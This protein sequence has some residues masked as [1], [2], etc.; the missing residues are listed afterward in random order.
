MDDLNF[1]YK[2]NRF[3]VFGCVATALTLVLPVYGLFWLDPT[4]P[5]FQTTF[6]TNAFGTWVGTWVG[7]GATVALALFSIHFSAV[8]IKD[9]YT[10][11]HLGIVGAKEDPPLA[12]KE[13]NDEFISYIRKSRKEIIL[14]GS[15]LS[16]FFRDSVFADEFASAVKF[17]GTKITIVFLDPN[18]TNFK[19]RLRE[20]V[21]RRDNLAK[22]LKGSLEYIHNY[23]DYFK[24]YIETGEIRIFMHNDDPISMNIF[25]KD[26]H[27]YVYLPRT[28]NDE[29]P[30]LRMENGGKFTNAVVGSLS[31][32]IDECEKRADSKIRTED[33]LKA[34]INEIDKFLAT[35][36]RGANV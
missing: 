6:G 1:K 26:V 25:D 19:D 14:S 8:T 31:R 35:T 33:D 23:Y 9:Y 29:S 20:E 22:R 34:R 2:S 21:G 24:P 15:S 36:G 10:F 32:I 13:Q 4:S 17:R 5:S 16:G 18:S 27:W 3:F 11:R 12:K 7:T 28:R 30:K